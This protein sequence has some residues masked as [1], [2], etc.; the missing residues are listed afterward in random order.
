MKKILSRCWLMISLPCVLNLVLLLERMNVRGILHP[1]S[2]FLITVI[3]LG[4]Y[5]RL[6]LLPAADRVK[7][8][9]RAR[10]MIGGGRLIYCGLY[11]M[12]VQAVLFFR[13]YLVRGW[14]QPPKAAVLAVNSVLACA[15]CFLL[16]AAGVLRIISGV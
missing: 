2:G 16:L 3:L 4:N 7:T 9:L 15:G 8:S 5:L 12:A 13:F 11:A 10:I 1:L 6:L 14:A